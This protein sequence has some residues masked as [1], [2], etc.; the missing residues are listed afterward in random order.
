MEAVFSDL[1]D[2]A[3]RAGVPVPRI[4]LARDL[5]RGIDPGHYPE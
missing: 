1:I 3:D 2:R 4:T 5:I